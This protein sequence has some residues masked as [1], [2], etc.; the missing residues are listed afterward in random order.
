MILRIGLIKVF[1]TRH[2][3]QNVQ[4]HMQGTKVQMTTNEKAAEMI[5]KL[6]Y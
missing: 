3:S 5:N 1:K 4:S 2:R 6:L